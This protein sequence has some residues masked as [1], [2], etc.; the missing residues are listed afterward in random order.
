MAWTAPP[1]THGLPR[2][3]P[4]AI[5]PPCG[6]LPVALLAVALLATPPAA[7]GTPASP[8]IRPD[9]PLAR[10]ALHLALRYPDLA[11]GTTTL[12]MTRL[13]VARMLLLIQGREGTATDAIDRGRRRRLEAALRDEMEI[14]RRGRRETDPL[15]RPVSS[16]RLEGGIAGGGDPYPLHQGDAGGSFAA[17]SVTGELHAGPVALVVEP[18]VA[19]DPAGGGNA[20]A[21]P[22]ALGGG[23]VLD[24]PRGYV[25]L[26]G[27]NL[28][29]MAGVGDMAWGPGRAGLIWSG[30]AAPPLAVRFTQP[31]P[32]RL[33][34]VLRWLGEFRFTGLWGLLRGV[35][36]DITNPQVLG[37]KLDARPIPWIEVSFARL[38]MLG[39]VERPPATAEDLWLLFWAANPHVSDDEARERFDA[40]D[41][42]SLDFSVDLPLVQRIPGVQFVQLY[43]SNGGEDTMQTSLG[44]LPLPSLTGQA[45]VGGAYLGVG[46]VTLRVEWARLRDDRFRW[47]GSHRIYADGFHHRGRVVG[48]PIDGDAE[49]T[50][51]ELGVDSGRRVE[52]W[53]WFERVHHIGV[54]DVY[55]DVVYTTIA[56]RY[57]TMAGLQARVELPSSPRLRLM[58]RVQIEHEQNVDHVPGAQAL[59][60]Q[61]WL[62][63]EV[64][65]Y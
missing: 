41:I 48:H 14:L 36:G 46:P 17:L 50:Y 54:I 59:W 23:A 35:N 34:W 10:D 65:T 22:V 37:M 9:D 60:P 29:L 44:S 56:D 63:L 39:G 16:L 61:L 25:K 3:T 15:V 11:P 38:S 27:G 47:Y 6:L 53:A 18:R 12:P 4:S 20:P 43:W 31:R 55:D 24:M 51:V 33:P 42:A 2:G 19:Y 13:E 49:G 1:R 52:A 30:N 5:A 45:N 7:A 21:G 57:R 64:P 8:D 62:A 32:W 28:E 26:A 40:N 58:A